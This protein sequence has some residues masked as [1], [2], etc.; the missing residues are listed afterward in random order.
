MNQDIR[1]LFSKYS[2]NK[3]VII[4]KKNIDL[5]KDIKEIKPKLKNALKQK[6]KNL[7]GGKEELKTPAKKGHQTP[8]RSN[9]KKEIIKETKTEMIKQSKVNKRNKIIDDDDI[10][11][12]DIDN[13]DN[14][15]GN[16][17]ENE[18][19]S[20]EEKKKEE[21]QK[22]VNSQINFK[23][24]PKVEKK[25]TLIPINP[26]DFFSGRKIVKKNPPK[27]E[28]KNI[29]NN[30]INNI[31]EGDV[32]MNNETNNSKNI[33][34]ESDIPKNNGS[35][36]SDKQEE[37]KQENN[38][39]MEI[40]EDDIKEI[41]NEMFNKESNSINN[42]S[43]NLQ[44]IPQKQ[45]SKGIPNVDSKNPQKEESKLNSQFSSSVH[46]S[47]I[48][49]SQPNKTPVQISNNHKEQTYQKRQEI[50]SLWS[51]KHKP[52]TR[53]D[54]VGN[55]TQIQ[56]LINWLDNWENAIIYGKK[57]EISYYN[58]NENLNA[59]A[60]IISGPPGIGKTSTVRVIAE[61]KNYHTF[62]LN[63][64]DK[65]N[66][67]IINNSVGFLMNNTTLSNSLLNSKN[68]IIM[69]EVDGMAGNEDK[70]GIKALIDIVKKTKTPI[71]FI[72]NDIY[73]Q[74]LKS[75]LN[76]CYDIRFT[77]PEKREIIG[78]LIQICKEEKMNINDSELEFICESFG[79]DIRQIIN[80]LELSSKMSKSINCQN[81][82]KDSAV[83][84][85][86]FDVCK[87]M[88]TRSELNKYPQFNQKLDLFFIDF[89][90][91]PNLIYENYLSCFGGNNNNKMDSLEKLVLSS[92]NISNGDVIEKRI[93]TKN[94]WSLLPNRG[95]HSTV[96]PSMICSSF[97]AY[98][99][100]PSYFSQ[101]SKMKKNKRQVRE[102]RQLFPFYSCQ[103]IRE[104]ISPLIY[105]IIMNI[106]IDKAKEGLD[107]IINIFTKL[108]MSINH[109]KESLF[110]LQSD[111][112]KVIYTKMSSA[113]KTAL[114]KKLN[115]HFK[116][117]IKVKKSTKKENESESI[118]KR[119][120][121]GNIIE[122][123]N[124]DDEEDNSEDVIIEAIE[125]SKGKGKTK[126][127]K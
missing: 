79:C 116:T 114:T 14:K 64:S 39:L 9:Q 33:I 65:R 40:D 109:F 94:D 51:D 98:P 27:N 124:E 36:K 118:V 43:H 60:A 34:H 108:K 58:K 68:L 3:P 29:T 115:E 20:I 57:R 59:R 30:N 123:I 53:S 56:N 88:L 107:D 55:T 80:Y 113:L 10:E 48:K 92:D 47:V 49:L 96:I 23:P 106:L 72:C 35:I 66:K 62:E 41:A 44:T 89:E 16:K 95:L 103:A 2:S 22:F 77:K 15:A 122:E 31:N 18:K 67:D 83:M 32:P 81:Y 127:K 38:D 121:E 42:V 71:I 52:K 6:A 8:S 69:D 70:G 120:A 73:C 25:E 102:I 93:K 75:L 119:D 86:S 82:K 112:R 110:D 50:S 24:I 5:S 28:E 104:E 87:K 21:K 125:P 117:S 19:M 4:E 74:K 91:I 37:E 78:R 13:M 90:L 7:P 54:I 45:E 46:R 99:K 63:A 101:I 17:P 26:M 12:G 76:Y 1:M 126:K 97:L 84:V 11:I 100:F 85:N 105:S 111:S 61:L